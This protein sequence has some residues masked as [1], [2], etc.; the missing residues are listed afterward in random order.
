MQLHEE[1]LAA[2]GGM[3]RPLASLQWAQ[4]GSALDMEV[5]QGTCYSIRRCFNVPD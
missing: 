3:G 2:G 5:A 1:A 4:G